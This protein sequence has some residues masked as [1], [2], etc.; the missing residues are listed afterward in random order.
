MRHQAAG[1]RTLGVRLRGVF[2]LV[3]PQNCLASA[4]ATLLGVHLGDGSDG[5]GPVRVAASMLVVCLILAASYVVNDLR[6]ADADVLGN[7]GRAIPSG[8]VTRREAVALWWALGAGGCLVAFAFGEADLAVMAVAC[9]AAG[10]VYSVR[11]KGTVLVGNAFVGLMAAT[12]VLYGSLAGG[13]PTAST[14]FAALIMFLFIFADE[15][16]KAIGDREADGAAG[17]RTVGT[18]LGLVQGLLVFRTIT[19]GFVAAALLP[20]VAGRAGVIYGAGVLL[21]AVG[22]ALWNVG[23]LARRPEAAAVRVALRLDKLVW[24][25]GL[26][27]LWFLG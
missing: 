10:V 4:L 12:P 17:L 14:W 1:P 11:L 23:A 25:T 27:A 16:L 8:R 9:L 6:D 13:S 20:L 3:R 7:P 26:W 22:P 19:L 5:A 18:R 2:D 21:G 15:V 24:F